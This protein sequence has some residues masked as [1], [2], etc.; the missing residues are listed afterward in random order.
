M[1]WTRHLTFTL[2]LSSA[3][4]Y[5][6]DL[7]RVQAK[8]S[9]VLGNTVFL[10][11]G[12]DAGLRAEDVV[13][14]DLPNGV[15]SEGRVRAVARQSARVEILPGAQV[16]TL[17]S[18][19]WA[20]IPRTRLS[21]EKPTEA[22]DPDKPLLAPAF[23]RGEAERES[24]THGRLYA[25]WNGVFDNNA[26]GRNYHYSTLG[27]DAITTNPFGAG[28]D[29]QLEAEWYM[30][31]TDS[32]GASSDEQELNLRRLSYRVGGVD[33]E[34]TRW[35]FGR[36]QQHAFPELGLLDGIEWS[37]MLGSGSSLGVSAGAMPLPTAGYD[38]FEDYQAALYFRGVSDSDERLVY[39]LAYQNTWHEGEQD[40]NLFVGTLDWDPSSEFSLNARMWVDLYDS[41]DNFKTSAVE[42][43]ELFAAAT[44]R[45]SAQTGWSLRGGHRTYPQLLRD[46]YTVTDPELLSDGYLDRAGLLWWHA[47]SS[48][49]R[50]NA[51]AD[52]WQDQDD[53]GLSFEAGASWRDLLWDNGELGLS[54]FYADGSYSSGPGGRISATKNWTS[55]FTT[56]AYSYTSYDQKG[57]VGDQA[58]LASHSI[59]GSL[60]WNVARDLD[61][62]LYAEDRFGD[63]LDSY[64]LGLSIQLRF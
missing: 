36:F 3:P 54:G 27:V 47:L 59:Y 6:Q 2:L 57:F 60:D 8:V 33:G 38:S 41:A 23:G 30:R 40:R 28:G 62:G 51:R 12:Q 18:P 39:G 43:S 22:W 49:T 29:L 24:R 50:L 5:A 14:F 25:R 20:E 10:D 26:N 11:Q 64:T 34:P 4:L 15:K 63:E 48:K 19:A 44:W 46:E 45:S 9:S 61:L 16:P 32:D 55:A 13:H 53:D 35:E 52:Y 56:L 42:I 58:T 17:G 7:V 31:Q 21:A 37:Q 1:S